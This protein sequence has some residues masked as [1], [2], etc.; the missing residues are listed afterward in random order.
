[1]KL[2]IK[3]FLNIIMVLIFI[4]N[5]IELSAFNVVAY[6][7]LL[8]GIDVSS[9]QKDI[10]WSAV[11]N[12]NISYAIIRTGTTNF[13]QEIMKTDNYF[14]KNYSGAKNNGLKVGAY[15]FTSAFTQEGMIQNAK[16]CLATLG[17]CSLDY[18]IFIDVEQESK[19]TKQVALG[20]ETLTNYL[21]E[22]LSILRNAGYSAGIYSN[23]SFLESYIDL[24]RIRSAG[25][26]VWMAQYP[27][28]SYA[29]N[30][31]N[32]DK[33]T[34]CTLWQ[35][36]NKGS[37]NGINGYCD[38]N[39]SYLNFENNV[40]DGD[41]YIVTTEYT[42]LNIRKTPNGDIIG[43]VPKGTV[44]NVIEIV[45]DG[46]WAKI[47]YNGIIGY[48]STKYLTPAS[49]N[50]IKQPYIT[51]DKEYY[52]IG[53]TVHI[54]WQPSPSNSN[55]SHYWLKIGG[56]NGTLLNETMG[57]N[58]TYDFILPEVGSYLI[59]AF[60][61]P[62]GSLEGEGSLTDSTQVFVDPGNITK[63]EA[64]TSEVTINRDID[65]SATV[66]FTCRN[67]PSNINS[68]NI[69]FSESKK[70]IAKIS[71]GQWNGNTLPVTFKGDMSGETDLTAYLKDDSSGNVLAVTTLH[72]IVKSTTSLFITQFYDDT[73]HIFKGS[74]LNLSESELT[75]AFLFVTG[76]YKDAKIECSA[77]E[78]SVVDIVWNNENYKSDLKNQRIY[79]FNIIPK[80]SGKEKITFNYLV[81]GKI[82]G[83]T[84]I[85]M[86]VY[87]ECARLQFYASG[88][89]LATLD[90]Q[91]GDSFEDYLYV[92]KMQPDERGNE[93]LGW[94]TS[95]LGGERYKDLD[96]IKENK[97]Y[98]LYA[99]YK[100]VSLSTTATS[101]TV[102]TSTLT[103]TKKSSSNSSN[104][105]G[106]ANNDSKVNIVDLVM[107]Q[108]YLLCSGKLVNWKNVDM[109]QDNKI[110]V[111]D[112]VMLRHLIISKKYYNS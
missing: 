49:E 103:T 43:T 13:N 58:T 25:Y 56:P 109:N 46:N 36:S 16:D 42:N 37:V 15:Y 51:T 80:S 86:E 59:T 101:P 90:A 26:Y 108:K 23:K 100:D 47:S 45:N 17:G 69:T 73:T 105:I 72:V 107:I 62:R 77:K 102:I 74:R 12:S 87:T 48:C 65:Q 27:S 89:L 68:L 97:V 60:A 85:D 84:F 28:G 21:L 83:S 61:T 18:P 4:I 99:H 8:Y 95:E 11:S 71:I 2:V 32:Y 19:S 111:F 91:I 96:T 79:G 33:S 6:D 9:Y 38:V 94:Y 30:P 10:D 76:P 20:K 41:K 78:N 44:I 92:L 1:M 98:S 53:E 31:A 55:I 75:N 110:D 39:V 3:K 93:F 22:A 104:M 54:S 70:N 67:V 35:F 81:E 66:F 24:S 7:T 106:D 29:V 50:D 82:V 52:N 64:T 88:N 5:I 14:S 63:L 112:L 34:N 57:L 40:E